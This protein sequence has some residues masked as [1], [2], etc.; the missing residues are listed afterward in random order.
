MSDYYCR[1]CE[2]RFVPVKYMNMNAVCPL[3]GSN[4]TEKIEENKAIKIDREVIPA[5]NRTPDENVIKDVIT[6]IKPK[7]EKC[8]FDK[9]EYVN[10]KE[11]KVCFCIGPDKCGDISCPR[12]RTYKENKKEEDYLI[13]KIFRC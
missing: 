12:V 9:Y 6:R 10:K 13:R 1:N 7:K 11:P 3:C 8:S 4:A 2:R 5:I